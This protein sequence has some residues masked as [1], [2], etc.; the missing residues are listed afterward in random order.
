MIRGFVPLTGLIIN[1]AVIIAATVFVY[2]E[3]LLLIFS[4]ALVFS[5]G[6]IGNYILVIPFLSAF[7]IYRKRQVLRVVA[8]SE[9]GGTKWLS[10]AIG[11]SLCSLAITLF[12]YGSSTLNALDYHIYSMPLFIAGATALLFNLKTL[13]YAFFA[14][15]LLFFLQPPSGELIG[16]AAADL[17]W[18]SAITLN[19]FFHLVGIDVRLEASFGAPSLVIE[20]PDGTSNTFAIGEPSSGVYSTIGMTVFSL[21]VAYIASGRIWKRLVILAVSLPLFF[22]LNMIRI[23][24]ILG[25]WY[26]SGEVAAE[27][28]HAV[29]GILMVS[30]GTLLLLVVGEK[31]LGIII[32]GRKETRSPC[33]MCSQSLMKGESFCLYCGRV[34]TPP[35]SKVRLR[36]MSGIFI[37]VALSSLT[38]FAQAEVNL[39]YA[40]KGIE[41]LDIS[42]L[43]GPE[44][45]QYMLP[46]VEGYEHSFAYRDT[47]TEN[48]LRQDLSIAYIY[49]GDTK[50][51]NQSDSNG[52]PIV[53][54]GMQIS[55][56]KHTWED[57]VLIHPSRVGRPTA[58][59][60]ELKNIRIPEGQEARFFV[61]QNPDSKGSEAV[62]YWFE[63]L[64]FNFGDHFEPRNLGII[65]WSPVD[66]LVQ[67]EII[68]GQDDI[69]GIERY[70]LTFAEPIAEHWREVRSQIVQTTLLDNIITNNASTFIILS[71]L[72]AIFMGVVH[73][74][75]NYRLKHQNERIINQLAIE[76]ERVLLN[77]LRE[78]PQGQIGMEIA[79]KYNF[80]EQTVNV[81]DL[82]RFGNLLKKAKDAG[83]LTNDTI[84][85]KDEPIMIWKPIASSL[86]SYLKSLWRTRKFFPEGDRR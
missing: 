76:E 68:A 51:P 39:A 83:F 52:Q 26:I 46:P 23:G 43:K 15:V 9:E 19:A 38:V 75:R 16:Q 67:T 29:G 73:S 66:S 3:D 72:P 1:T 45:T 8:S 79:Q 36:T 24:T 71:L 60:I 7:V 61:Y 53:F 33:A 30:I 62:L 74:I 65:I 17:S 20:K 49:K 47:S 41:K 34:F 21:F 64:P 37:I 27:A 31:L 85:I 70:F 78:N 10:A 82:S 18:I 54:V 50:S 77:S 58:D 44:T 5:S 42:S 35:K 80:K 86:G 63:R 4:K 14:I 56:G 13:R 32:Y 40:G 59:V 28:F 2:G 48:L 12:I 6:N 84:T 11:I 81:G 25:I 69:N 55:T 57:S 22:A